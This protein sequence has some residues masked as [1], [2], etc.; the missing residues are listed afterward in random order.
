MLPNENTVPADDP[1]TANSGTVIARL[2][3]EHN[4][5]LLGF[6]RLRLNSEQDAR[7][8]AQEA[9]VRL[10]QLDQPGAVSFLRSY[11]FRIASNLA[12][13]RLRHHRVRGEVTGDGDA[14]YGMDH[15]NPE[16]VAIARQQLT[17]V[18]AVLKKLPEK[19]RRVFLLCRLAGLS[20]AEAGR[21]LGISERTAL[22]YVVKA[23]VECRSH[24]DQNRENERP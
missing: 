20:A 9:Y 6:L 2:F 18:E 22:N 19:V 8:V 3:E 5:A 16:R 1:D 4:A 23:M 21:R 7:E 13:D 17:I 14:G 10:L 12:T 24:L 11:L 15:I